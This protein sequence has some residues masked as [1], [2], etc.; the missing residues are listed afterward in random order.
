MIFSVVRVSLERFKNRLSTIEIEKYSFKSFTINA[1]PL[2][3]IELINVA[4]KCSKV[5]VK[6]SKSSSK[7]KQREGNK[8]GPTA[9]V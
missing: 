9:V 2:K 8:K 1:L 7:N 5:L 3:E 4:E 6:V